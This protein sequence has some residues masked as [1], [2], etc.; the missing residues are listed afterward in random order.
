MAVDALLP[1]TL[2]GPLGPIAAVVDAELDAVRALAPLADLRGRLLDG[3][4]SSAAVGR[5]GGSAL[6]A[7][8]DEL[9]VLL[10]DRDLSDDTRRALVLGALEFHRRRGS[11]GSLDAALA[12]LGADAA[13]VVEPAEQRAVS[14]VPHEYESATGRAWLFYWNE[15]LVGLPIDDA[16]REVAGGRP[17][18]AAVERATA[19]SAPAHTRY[20]L[21]IAYAEPGGDPA[22]TWDQDGALY[23]A[24]RALG[25]AYDVRQFGP[26]L[27][28]RPLDGTWFLAPNS[29]VARR[30]DAG[31]E[32]PAELAPGGYALVGDA[33]GPDD[34]EVELQPWGS[35]GY[36]EGTYTLTVMGV[37][38]ELPYAEL[39]GYRAVA[40]SVPSPATAPA[41]ALE[42]GPADGDP[43]GA[44]LLLRPTDPPA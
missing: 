25:A 1:P 42:D 14:E 2:R 21:Q 35:A 18:L 31:L 43:L 33:P 11:R 23:E 8:A 5:L 40:D 7:L 30:R 22:T 38:Y 39:T 26:S 16:F 4:P 34:T 41:P 15:F 36:A 3:T 17:M 44:V 13:D 24:R 10:Y 19:V 20:V 9:D 28:G 6:D 32:P 12:L 29:V 27:G 37:E